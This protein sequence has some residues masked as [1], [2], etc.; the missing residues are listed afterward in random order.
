VDTNGFHE[1]KQNQFFVLNVKALLGIKRGKLRRGNKFSMPK[2]KLRKN[3]RETITKK[4]RFEVFKRDGFRCVYCG[5][6]PPKVILE[7]DHIDPVSKG[8]SND[9]NNYVTACFDCNR[10]KSNI[11]LN[12]IPSKV[13]ENLEVLKEKEEQLAE[14]RKFIN[15]IN[16]R[17][18]KDINDISKIY[19]TQYVKWGFS[20][21]FKKTSLKKFLSLLPKHEVEESLH[22]AISR[23]PT[24]E[25]NVIK[26]FCGVCW[27]K[28]KEEDP[29]NKIK[30][31]WEDLSSKYNRGVGYSK[32]EDINRIKNINI[33]TLEEH[34][35]K[36]L[37]KRSGSYWKQFILFLEESK[38]I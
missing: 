11:K 31:L 10:G 29:L 30:K 26:Y 6:E 19:L 18:K 1:L 25:D 36:S 21:N 16:R 9:I 33:N 37:E 14:Y 23:F 13:S 28:I 12:K 35:C 5:G 24:D 7:V 2:L 34:M 4:I 32:I 8:G 22:I 38:I 27:N 20:D 15:K 17:V 3:K